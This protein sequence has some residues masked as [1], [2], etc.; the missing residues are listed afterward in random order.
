MDIV[1]KEFGII[2]SLYLERIADIAGGNPRL[3]V[4]AGALAKRENRLNK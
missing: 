2:N 1:S 3:A 4:M